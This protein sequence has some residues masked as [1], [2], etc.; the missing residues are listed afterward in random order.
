MHSFKKEKKMSGT[1]VTVLYIM[2]GVF[3]VLIAI[4][5]VPY[6]MVWT[7]TMRG[8]AKMREAE[9]S[10][11]IA[12]IEAEAKKNAAKMLAEAEILRAEGVA[13]ANKI[14]GDSLKG[15]EAYLRYLWIQSLS[16]GHSEVIYVPTEA[17][18]P[19]LESVRHLKK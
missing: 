6:Y 7:Q 13:K 19:I 3:L 9:Y 5:G 8:M 10:R 14:I 16:D 11:K 2:A 12:V 4:F 17:N 15:N 18:L 1:K